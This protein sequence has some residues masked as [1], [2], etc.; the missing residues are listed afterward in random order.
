VEHVV[1]VIR[2]RTVWDA[3]LLKPTRW[4]RLAVHAKLDS[5]SPRYGSQ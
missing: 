4:V 1:W 3:P 5:E 2:L